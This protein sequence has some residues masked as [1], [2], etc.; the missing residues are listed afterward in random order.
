MSD[1]NLPRPL[2]LSPKDVSCAHIPRPPC[3]P[4]TA[5]TGILPG[6]H[7]LAFSSCIKTVAPTSKLDTM[8][9]LGRLHELIQTAV[10]NA[11][12]SLQPSCD[13]IPNALPPSP[14]KNIAESIYGSCSTTVT[15][16]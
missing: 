14:L 9:L 5:A 13:P 7:V 10:S 1:R 3:F 2:Y 11:T 4:T 8:M 6:P 12:E 15:A 16:P